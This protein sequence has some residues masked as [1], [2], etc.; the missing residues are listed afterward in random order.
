[1]VYQLFPLKQSQKSYNGKPCFITKE[2][3]ENPV[4]KPKKYGMFSSHSRSVKVDLSRLALV[5]FMT[6]FLKTQPLIIEKEPEKEL[7]PEKDLQQDLAIITGSHDQL[8]L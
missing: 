7:L 2:K 1:M 3:K 4:L 8:S 5:C 6:G